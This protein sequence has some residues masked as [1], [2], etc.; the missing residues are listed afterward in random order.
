MLIAYAFFIILIC[1]FFIVHNGFRF[2]YVNVNF[3]LGIVVVTLLGGGGI[4]FGFFDWS[5]FV[6]PLS[7]SDSVRSSVLFILMFSSVSY[8]ISIFIFSGVND[9]VWGNYINRGFVYDETS[10]L[11]FY[12]FCII[13]IL[14][15][16]IYQ[17]QAHPSVLFQFLSGSN[18]ETLA[19]RRVQLGI[20]Y[21]TVGVTYIKTLA[22]LTTQVVFL[23][24]IALYFNKKIKLIPLVFFSIVCFVT[25]LSAGDKAPI[26]TLVVSTLCLLTYSNVKL[27]FLK[28]VCCLLF[29]AFVFLVFYSYMMDYDSNILFIKLIER[30]FVAQVVAVFGAYELYPEIYPFAGFN[31]ISYFNTLEVRDVAASE[32]LTHFYNEMRDWGAW[33]VNGLY[34]H[35]AWSNW[36]VVGL[37]FAPIYAGL[38]NGVF[39]RFIMSIKKSPLSLGVFSFMSGNL[40]YFLTGFNGFVFNLQYLSVLVVFLLAWFF[41]IIISEA[42][43]A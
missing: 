34:I 35:E 18:A 13:S 16:V 30:V 20:E 1:V 37:I 5:Y 21:Y 25:V 6:Q 14:T 40:G 11:E 38:I 4:A 32:I 17:V 10:K 31:S 24:C 22:V 19:F 15:A 41:S 8:L 3:W 7:N 27:P 33:N 26:V 9:K 23:S 28:F 29:F 43:N 42:T 2:D 39:V 36:G 12:I